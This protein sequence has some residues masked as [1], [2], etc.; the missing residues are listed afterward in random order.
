MEPSIKP[1]VPRVYVVANWGVAND[2]RWTR[3]RSGVE[4]SRSARG[5]KH[6]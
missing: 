1:T 3:S 6:T 5:S 2:E 4:K